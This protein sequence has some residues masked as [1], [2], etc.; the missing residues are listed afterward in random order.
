MTETNCT[1]LSGFFFFPWVCK[2]IEILLPVSQPAIVE[3]HCLGGWIN[4]WTMRKDGETER[5]RGNEALTPNKPGL[6]LDKSLPN[7]NALK[8]N[9]LM[10]CKVF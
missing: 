3:F 7:G 4:G 8:K 6:C 9:V 1:R 5:E 10:S 2:L